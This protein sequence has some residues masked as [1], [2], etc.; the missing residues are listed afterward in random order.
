MI[1]IFKFSHFTCVRVQ[2]QI[3]KKNTV[4]FL[5]GLFWLQVLTFKSFKSFEFIAAHDVNKKSNLIVLH[6]AIQFSHHHIL[7]RLSVSH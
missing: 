3:K 2:I 1:L 7:K 6:I 4:Y 5:P